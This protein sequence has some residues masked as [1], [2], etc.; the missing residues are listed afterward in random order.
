M[1]PSLQAGARYL[2][3]AAESMNS[4]RGSAGCLIEGMKFLLMAVIPL[5]A[6]IL[7]HAHALG[8]ATL[9]LRVFGATIAFFSGPIGW[10]TAGILAL[11]AAWT[12]LGKVERDAVRDQQAFIDSIRTMKLGDLQMEL[13]D[14]ER[15]LSLMQQKYAALKQELEEEVEGDLFSAGKAKQGGGPGQAS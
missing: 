15:L 9:A 14:T 1:L 13:R 12:L 8:I 5:A 10:I 11:A 3:S 2:L 6:A 7:L 4:M